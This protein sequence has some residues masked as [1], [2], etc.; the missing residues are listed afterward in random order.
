MVKTESKLIGNEL[1]G[2]RELTVEWKD[3]RT[4]R[5][6]AE[7][8]GMRIGRRLIAMAG[9]RMKLDGYTEITTQ[10]L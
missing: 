2:T 3:V 6:H 9:E 1:S 5:E 10:K 4:K 8:L 7:Y